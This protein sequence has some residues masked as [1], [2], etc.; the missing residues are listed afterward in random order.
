MV[1]IDTGTN[2]LLCE[3]SDRVATVTLN[4]PHKKNALGDRLTPALRN[5]LPVLEDREDV[6]CVM[7]IGAGNAFCSG[8]DVSEMGGSSSTAT[9]RSLDERIADL[10][11]RQRTLTGRIYHLTK[12]TVAAL[13]GAAAG[14]GFSIVLAC[15]LRIAVDSAFVLTAFRNIGLSGDYG[16]SWFLP[17]LIGLSRAKSLFYRSSRVD[18]SEAKRIGLFDEVFPIESFREDAFNY[19]KEIANGPTRALGMMKVNLQF[20]LEQSLD[21]SFTLEAE[22]MIQSGSGDEARKAIKAFVE[23]RK[24]IFHE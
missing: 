2:E 24:P 1:E 9:P 16:A 22:H 3:I 7:I 12:P 19:A 6:G 23:K 14:A 20:G 18:A 4:K 11:E 21:A 8:G 15:D 5:I 13:S 10:A 17:R